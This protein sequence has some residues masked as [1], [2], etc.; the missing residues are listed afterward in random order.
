MVKV[1]FSSLLK[2]AF[3]TSKVGVDASGLSVRNL[4]SKLGQMA[5]EGECFPNQ[6]FRED[7]SLRTGTTIFINGRHL[8]EID[9]IG[10]VLKVGDEV[11]L[12]RPRNDQAP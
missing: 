8:C 9:L 6:I 5:A 10:A 4:V 2:S 7:G 11:G 1:I 12:F 3:R